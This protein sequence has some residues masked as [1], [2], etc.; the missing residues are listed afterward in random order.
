MLNKTKE[1][2]NLGIIFHYDWSKT[3]FVLY[4]IFYELWDFLLCLMGQLL[5]LCFLGALRIDHCNPFGC[6]FSRS[7]LISSKACT[8]RYSVNTWGVIPSAVLQSCLSLS[9][10]LSSFQYS[11]LKTL[12]SLSFLDFQLSS[13][14]KTNTGFCLGLLLLKTQLGNFLEVAMWENCRAHLT[15]SFFFQGSCSFIGW[16]SLS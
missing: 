6:F 5:F 10:Y 15:A 14:L 1:A 9:M 2:F 8:D 16:C 4:L 13:Q 11:N 7:W 3:S 12:V